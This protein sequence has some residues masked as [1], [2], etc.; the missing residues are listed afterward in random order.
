MEYDIEKGLSRLEGFPAAAGITKISLGD[1][2]FGAKTNEDMGSEFIQSNKLARLLTADSNFHKIIPEH[3]ERILI[4]E[5]MGNYR[6]G[7]TIVDHSA[8]PNNTTILFA[9]TAD[10]P[11]VVLST[12]DQ[13]L[14]AIIH[15]GWKGCRLGIVKKTIALIKERYQIKPEDLK[16][17]L[18][19]GICLNCYEVRDDVGELFSAYYKN[20]RLNF[21]DLILSQLFDSG[22]EWNNVHLSHYCSFHSKEAGAAPDGPPLFFSN[23]RGDQTKRNVVFITRR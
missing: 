11:I 12:P 6:H 2:G 9:T 10:C 1:F 21:R 23:R 16:A 22:I 20:G 17:G 4:G 18:F 8:K 13:K 7:D 15:S 3:G 19:P 14:I 5:D